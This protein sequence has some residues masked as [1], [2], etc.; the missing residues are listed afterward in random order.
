MFLTPLLLFVQVNPTSWG[1]SGVNFTIHGL[2]PEYANGSWPQYCCHTPDCRFN[3]SA[4]S[5][6]TSNLTK[7]W[8]NYHKHPKELWYHEW[9]KH[10][11]CSGLGEEQY[12]ETGLR[13]R[14]AAPA[15]DMLFKAQ[16]QP[17]ITYQFNTFIKGLYRVTKRRLSITCKGSLLEQV[18]QC[19]WNGV[20]GD[21]PLTVPNRCPKTLYY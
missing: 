7:W 10:G 6:I 14:K 15:G 17:N 1:G 2:W 3:A 9:M 8:T 5:N 19:Y 4:I 13:L 11:V 16:L 18:I 12:F 20:W 21:C